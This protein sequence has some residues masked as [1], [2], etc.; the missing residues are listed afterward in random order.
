MS[1]YVISD[2][3][4]CYDKFMKMLKLIN[5]TNEDD[6]YIIG[7][8]FDRGA[9]P[10]DVLDYVLGHK[11]IHLIK[12]NHE[13]MFENYFVDGNAAFWYHNGGNSTHSQIMQKGFLAEEDLYRYIRNLPF[14]KVVD[15][16][17]LV[18]GGLY[19]PDNY[20]ELTLEELLELQ[21][22]DICLWNRDNVYSDIKF[23]DY[24]VISGH[25]IVQCID[26]RLNG[27]PKII[28]RNGHIFIDCGACFE[29]LGGKLSCLRL[30]DMKEFYI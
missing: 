10:L 28:H 3:H 22:E 23:K 24:I 8:I 21:E 19:F 26:E 25:T 12:G 1:K 30:D 14:I 16:F 9:Q 17:I 2:I 27:N 6:L 13:Q 5:F 11:N 18:H 4:G 15:Q 20:E 29:Q 7:D